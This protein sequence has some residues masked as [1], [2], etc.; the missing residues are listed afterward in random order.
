[1]VK[2][3][4]MFGAVLASLVCPVQATYVFETVI[5]DSPSMHKLTDKID[6]I[7]VE[8]AKYDLTKFK[9]NVTLDPK[10]FNLK[11]DQEGFSKEV[12]TILRDRFGIPDLNVG[13]VFAH[14]SFL[15]DMVICYQ[16]IEAHAVFYRDLKNKM[17]D[18]NSALRGNSS[19]DDNWKSNYKL[20]DEFFDISEGL[21]RSFKFCL[22]GYFN[23]TD[24]PDE[25]SRRAQRLH[26]SLSLME[27]EILKARTS[28]VKEL[29]EKFH[30][31]NITIFHKA[32]VKEK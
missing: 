10:I 29:V 11:G 4:L 30:L 19:Y 22:L 24:I 31:P 26:K 6:F 14:K 9:V 27:S 15:E 17:D 16:E 32:V 1:M 13:M 23:T 28:Q 8:D 12:T 3:I 18:K 7:F 5:T 21:I 2:Y 25:S 20:V